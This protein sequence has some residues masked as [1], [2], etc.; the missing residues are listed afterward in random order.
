MG[1]LRISVVMPTFDRAQYICEALD[2]LMKQSSPP[3]EVLV[4]DD[5]STDDTRDRVGRHPFVDRIRY[6]LQ[7]QRGGA[8][9]AR[10]TGV[11]LAWGQIV[12]FLDSDDI[13]E[14]DHHRRVEETF[15]GAPGVGL[16]CCDSMTI[17]S[18]GQALSGKSWTAIQADITGR[19][20]G[21]GVRSLAEIFHFS[22]PFPGMAVRRD[23]YLAVGGLDQSLFPLDDL[24]LQ[25]K[26]A[27]AGHGVFYENVPRARYRIHEDNESGQRRA[28]RACRMK[29]R[30]TVLARKRYS[31][32]QELPG[33]GRM[34]QG[35]VRRELAIA[36]LRDGRAFAGLAELLRSLAEDP[37]G[38]NEIVR[39]T[40]RKLLKNPRQ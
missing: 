12:V 8:S 16:Y 35:E 6:Y 32:I 40:V 7:P 39:L 30:C 5:R 20:I 19:K 38:L 10:N 15:S 31:A 37:R 33:A 17:G 1:E 3:S 9:I 4:I 36:L 24:D 29:L 34:R 13:L 11:S 2:S 26:V 27:G 18:G 25:M 21:T 22:T 14:P 23:V 28:V